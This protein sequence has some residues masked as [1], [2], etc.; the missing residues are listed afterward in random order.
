M[1]GRKYIDQYVTFSVIIKKHE[2]G[3][4]IKH[5]TIFFN[6]VS[7][8]ASLLSSLTDNLSEALRKSKRKDCKSGL[9]YSQKGHQEW[10]LLCRTQ[11]SKSQ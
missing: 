5:K 7:F 11:I 3:K 8:M 10:N 9:E 1:F 6:G 2:I 4:T